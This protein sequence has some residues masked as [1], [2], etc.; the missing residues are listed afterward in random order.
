MKQASN[1]T[2]EAAAFAVTRSDG[3]QV[4]LELAGPLTYASLGPVWNACIHAVRRAQPKTLVIDARQVT[5]C[6][7]AGIGFLSFLLARVKKKKFSAEIV[8]LRPEL[9]AMLE[10]FGQ[11]SAPEPP[12]P[13]AGLGAI[14]A[15]GKASAEFFADVHSQI[16]FFARI[17]LTGARMAAHPW[18][19]RWKDFFVIA[20][21][22]GFRALEIV[23][24]LGFLFGLI[25]AF[26][27]AMPLRQFGVEIYVADLVAIALVRVLGPFITAVIVAGR[28]GSA[29]AAEIGTMKINN[30]IDALEVMNMDPVSFL[31]L[32]RV[33]AALLVTPLLT[34]MANLWGLIGS[35]LV[36]RSLG[37]PLVIYL[38]HVQSILSMTDVLVGLV[39]AV[40]FGG[41][42]G[43][44]GCLRG[45]QTQLGA[46]AVGIA[47]TRAVVTAIILLVLT[48]GV[49]SVLLHFLEI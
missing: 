29:Y 43:M 39:K 36:I 9:Q 15:L 11:P 40:I 42:V 24:L 45:L 35:G 12:A 34:V 33:L 41:L 20:E 17:L 5:T 31:V 2:P 7:G 19:F 26:S 3:R 14:A 13:P 49:F 27:S 28:T 38:S 37:Y 1:N 6:D 25:I 18:R 44:V 48:E 30:E 46:G 22:A 16:A 8:G 32:P 21:L 47:T 23:S 10:R 4:R